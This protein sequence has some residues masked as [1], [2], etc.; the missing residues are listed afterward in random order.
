MTSCDLKKKK[1]GANSPQLK[2]YWGQKI[3]LDM[4]VVYQIQSCAQAELQGKGMGVSAPELAEQSL[5]RTTEEKT[6]TSCKLSRWVCIK[7]FEKSSLE[8]TGE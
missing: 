4:T 6:S 3:I 8:H 7:V 5:Q 1:K 2:I